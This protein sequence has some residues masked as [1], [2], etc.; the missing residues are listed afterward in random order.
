MADHDLTLHKSHIWRAARQE[1]L[2]WQGLLG[3]V[4][5]FFGTLILLVG[6]GIGMLGALSQAHGLVQILALVSYALIYWIMFLLTRL[7]QGYVRAWTL[8]RA[9]F[10]TQE[11]RPVHITL[12]QESLSLQSGRWQVQVA[13]SAS[14]GAYAT[15]DFLFL[16]SP[17]VPWFPLPKS[18]E[19]EAIFHAARHP[20]AAKK[21]AAEAAP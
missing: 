5:L 21:G 7:I 11:S 8:R 17:L 20:E 6:L 19:L 9:L 15:R 14:L 12:S 1:A 13:V 18:G 10:R 4:P 16:Q 3:R 2:R